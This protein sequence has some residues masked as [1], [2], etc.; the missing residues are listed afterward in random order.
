M[1]KP[2]P[3]TIVALVALFVSL[4]GTT[5][6]AIKL[7]ANSVGTKQIRDGAV[8]NRDLH[9]QAVTGSKVADNSLTG[10][11][12][13]S[14]TLGT[15]PM[16]TRATSADHA[17]DAAHADNSDHAKTSDLLAGSPASTYLVHCPTGLH[18]APKT[19]ICF[20]FT[21]R[22]AATWTD[23][24][25]TCVAAGLRLPD[26]GELAQVFDD[27]GAF[28]DFQW[29]SSQ[30]FAPNAA[31]GMMSQ[32]SSRNISLNADLVTRAHPYRCIT[33]ASD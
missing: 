13:N 10:A 19:D 11:Q 21:E 27:L 30:F 3:A 29:T 23:A 24:L 26:P 31:A 1:G 15:V 33:T 6:A 18:R 2:T 9:A 17:A 12:I 7:P 5:Y 8:A 28:Q 32:D 14:S 16:A 25:K 22:A 4:G 20:D